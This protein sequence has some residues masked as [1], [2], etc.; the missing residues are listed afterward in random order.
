MINYLLFQEAREKAREIAERFG[1][2]TED[3]WLKFCKDGKKPKN[4]PTYPRDM[5]EKEGWVGFRDWI[6]APNPSDRF[7][8]YKDAKKFVAGIDVNSESKWRKYTK[9]DEF[10]DF[11]PVDPSDFYDDWISWYDFFGKSDDERKY[12]VNDDYFSKW[13]SDMAYI[14]GFWFA[15]GYMRKTVDNCY[16]FNFKQHKRDLYLLENIRSKMESNY[17]ISFINGTNCYS[18]TINSKKI[19]EDII[20]LGGSERKSLTVKFPD[21]PKEYLP[22]FIRGYFDGDGTISSSNENFG[23]VAS[24]CSGSRKFIYSL[25]KIVGSIGIKTKMYAQRVKKG[26]LMF[27]ER[28]L[29]KDCVV[30]YLSLSPTNAKLLRNYMYKTQS[31]L[32]MIRKWERFVKSGEIHNRIKYLSFKKA[33]KFARQHNFKDPDEYK[34]MIRGNEKEYRLP[35]SADR[36]YKKY[37]RGWSYFL[38]H[39]D[40]KTYNETVLDWKNRVDAWKNNEKDDKMLLNNKYLIAPDYSSYA[41]C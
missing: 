39:T 19:Y 41:P 8:S 40:K 33:V 13:S 28:R 26:T 35:L 6:G 1:I 32:K 7:L 25:K 11:L 18:F 23:Y 31:K 16:L 37:W 2:K 22:D 38:G 3:E 17:P 14:L 34:K 24:F 30:Y 5:Y 9:L 15:D 10:P 20:K 21:V 27:G 4:I 12:K 29:K 36:V